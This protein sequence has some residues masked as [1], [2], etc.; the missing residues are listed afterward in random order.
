MRN[1]QPVTPKE[2]TYSDDI[3]IDCAPGIHV[4]ITRKEAEEWDS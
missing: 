4:F 3:R 1:N 2:V